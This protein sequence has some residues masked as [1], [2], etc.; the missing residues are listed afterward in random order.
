MSFVA[1]NW[2]GMSK[3]T[4]LLVLIAGLWAAYGGAAALAQRGQQRFADAAT[5]TGVGIFGAGIMLISQMYHMEGN[6]P[7]A[8][9]MWA[10]G[11]LTAG[12]LLRSNAATAA[13]MPLTLLWSG[14]DMQLT[15]GGH[16]LFL[17]AWAA[18]AAVFYWRRWWPGL[19]LAIA[20]IATWI[21]MI[22]EIL[23]IGYRNSDRFG[24]PRRHAATSCC[25]GAGRD[26]LRQRARIHRRVRLAI[27]PVLQGPGTDPADRRR[28]ARAA[29]GPDRLGLAHLRPVPRLA[30]LRGVF[31]RDPRPLLQDPWHPALD[32][33]VL[34]H[35]RTDRHAARRSG[36]AAGE[37]KHPVQGGRIVINWRSKIVLAAAA[38][39]ALQTAVLAWIVHG[40]IQ[41]LRHGAELELATVPVDPRSLFRGDYVILSYPVSRAP[42]ALLGD[43]ASVKRGER[44]YATLGRDAAGAWTVKALARVRP[45]KPAAG[46]M[47]LEARAASR[48][49]LQGDIQLRYG[50]ESY[51][52]PEGKGRE[53]EKMVGQ[54]KLAVLV[55]VDAKGQSA[56][57]GLVI[58]GKR[59][60]DEP[61]I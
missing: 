18:I 48:G 34:P 27:P 5:L 19:H 43:A 16:W 45:G 25:I 7:D 11:A 46:E 60:Y 2:Q 42:A 24:M 14:W 37:V 1:A 53:L 21:V 17:P 49:G 33:A 3:L 61:L 9:L 39:A 10:I 58:D 6:P 52:V 40:R 15:S 55:A 26:G 54:R 38:V 36:L 56:I 12:V 59:I 51:F 4:R 35:R 50:L 44:L 47:V 13:A 57:K 22:T 8:V 28:H 30:R 29:V 31:D 20:A 41:L 23:G 32:I